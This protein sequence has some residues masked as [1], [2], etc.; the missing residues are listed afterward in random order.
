[1]AEL[2]LYH[3]FKM[4]LCIVHSLL[5]V[6]LIKFFS[7]TCDLKILRLYRFQNPILSHVSVA[8]SFPHSSIHW[9]LRPSP[10][11]SDYSYLHYS[12][13]WNIFLYLAVFEE[14]RPYP[15]SSE[16]SSLWSSWFL[17]LSSFCA[18]VPPSYMRHLRILQCINVWEVRQDIYH[19]KPRSILH[20][21]LLHSIVLIHL[22]LCNRTLSL[23]L[24]CIIRDYV[25]FAK[26]CI[27]YS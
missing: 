3:T 17:Q 25:M 26:F 24:D 14:S 23:R 27:F 19:A 5:T 21:L 20:Q 11:Y 6:L 15:Y 10:I 8:A 7:K 18:L 2:Q 22:D 9:W 4:W 13:S 1:M 12:W 16:S